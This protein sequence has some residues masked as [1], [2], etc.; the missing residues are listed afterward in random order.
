VTP[1]T[2]IQERT[3]ETDETVNTI[4]L[5]IAVLAV[6]EIIE[7]WHHSHLFSEWRARV[8]LWESPVADML[9]CPFCMAPWASLLVVCLILTPGGVLAELPRL[10][11][12]ALAIARAAN[13]LNDWQRPFNRTPKFDKLADA[14][15]PDGGVPPA[16][17]DDPVPRDP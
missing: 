15:P 17:A 16:E 5:L 14:D 11:V 2:P 6:S 10:P 12:Y 8:D 9:R 4:T 1:L 3:D 7:V 13:L